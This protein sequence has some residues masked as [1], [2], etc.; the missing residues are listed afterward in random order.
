[1]NKIVKIVISTLVGAGCFS[2]GLYYAT[3]EFD[4]TLDNVMGEYEVISDKVNAFVDV[5]N[6]ETIRLYTKELRRILD[7]IKFLHV[8]VESGQIADEKLDEYLAS[9]QSNV[10]VLEETLS[11]ITT[12]VD[13]IVTSSHDH[14]HLM[15]EE[16]QDSVKTQLTDTASEV[17]TEVNKLSSQFKEVKNQLDELNKVIDKIKNSKMSKYLK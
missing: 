13:S 9:K 15:V 5:S 17:S 7:D 1:M 3:I 6:P 2:A 14:M 16:L 8:L 4:E 12:E 10:D 11:S